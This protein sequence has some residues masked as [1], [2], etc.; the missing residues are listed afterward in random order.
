MTDSKL[1]V[2]C[3]YFKEEEYV[4]QCT[5]PNEHYIEDLVYGRQLIKQIRWC[6]DERSRYKLSDED[7][8]GTQGQYYRKKKEGTKYESLSKREKEEWG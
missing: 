1:C 4:P 8:C 3:V 2:D 6:Y 7:V 5:I